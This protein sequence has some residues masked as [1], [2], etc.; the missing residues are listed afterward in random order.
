MPLPTIQQVRTL[1]QWSPLLGFAR[2]WSAEPNANRQG[3]ILADALEWAASQTAG[4][5]DDQLAQHIA[6]VLRTHEGA[7]LVRLLLELAAQMEA[8]S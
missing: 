1:A 5:I 6:A 2:R 3:E 4:R 8:K 7:A